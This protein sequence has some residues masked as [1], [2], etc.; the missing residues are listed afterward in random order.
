MSINWNLINSLRCRLGIGERNSI[1]HEEFQSMPTDGASG[2]VA[3]DLLGLLFWSIL[4]RI[5]PGTELLVLGK[6]KDSGAR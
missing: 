3:G 6:C 1:I 4:V 5:C 2:V